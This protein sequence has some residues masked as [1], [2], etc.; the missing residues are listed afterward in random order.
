MIDLT[1]KQAAN[2]KFHLYIIPQSDTINARVLA[3]GV[4]EVETVPAEA[5]CVLFSC[6]GNCYIRH[7]AA[8]AIP[9]TDVTDGTAS[10]LNPSGYIVAAADTI[11]IIAP[12]DC[13]IT[14]AYY[15]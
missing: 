14:L 13:V 15:K 10:E 3:A 2:A 5:R 7:N 1:I 11:G 4:A 9:A 8:A 12:A 6:T